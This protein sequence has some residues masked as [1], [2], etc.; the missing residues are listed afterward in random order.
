MSEDTFILEKRHKVVAIDGRKFVMRE[1]G[2]EELRN[3]SKAL[4]EA[5]RSLKASLADKQDLESAMMEAS[6]TE[7]RLLLKLLKEPVDAAR[8][9]DKAFLSDLS[10]SQR[11]AIFKVQD[12]LNDMENLLKKMASLLA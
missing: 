4:L 11:Q 9:A 1:M 8:P 3:Y 6:E 10:Y 12:D 7:I 2:A 5:S